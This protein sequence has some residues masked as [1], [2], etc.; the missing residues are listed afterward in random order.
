MSSPIKVL[1]HE[2]FEWNEKDLQAKPQLA[3]Y[4][5]GAQMENTDASQSTFYESW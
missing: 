2:Q 4:V 5:H 3:V 1:P